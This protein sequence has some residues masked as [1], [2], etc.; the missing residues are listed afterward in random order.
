MS[1][2]DDDSTGRRTGYGDESSGYGGNTGSRADDGFGVPPSAPR[3][4]E[5]DLTNALQSSGR[6]TDTYGEVTMILSDRLVAGWEPTTTM[7]D[8]SLEVL[9]FHNNG[10]RLTSP[11][12]SGRSG[13]GGGDSY[14][15]SGR[16]GDD[17]YG[18]TGSGYGTGITGGAGSGNKYTSGAPESTRLDPDYGTGHSGETTD[19]HEP[20]AGHN[21]YGSG[22][23]GGAGFGNKTSGGMAEDS[24]FAGNPDVARNSDPYSS[25]GSYGSGAT[26]GAGFGNK[27]SNRRDNDDNEKGSGT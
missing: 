5:A 18:S 17:S 7:A 22:S 6:D 8:V 20:Y 3:G 13:I 2:Y 24:S 16:G 14:G 4:S 9:I 21:E 12:S 15:S 11:Q 10:F 25:H 23:V 19:R 26:G 27:S 1:S